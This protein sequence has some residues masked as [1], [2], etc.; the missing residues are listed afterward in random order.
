MFAAMLT[1]VELNSSLA[2]DGD[3]MSNFGLV[4]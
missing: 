2:L 3:A 1:S 4:L